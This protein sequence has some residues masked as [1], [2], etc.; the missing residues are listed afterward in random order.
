ME[1]IAPPKFGEDRLKSFME[2]TKKNKNGKLDEDEQDELER[3][4]FDKV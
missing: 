2:S 4:D 3:K 1:E